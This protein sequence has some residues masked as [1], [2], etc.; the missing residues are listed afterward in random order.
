M[1][2][3]DFFWGA[4]TSS[5][6]IEGAGLRSDWH[7]WEGSHGTTASLSGN[8][9]R[10]RFV[11]DFALLAEHQL[12]QVRLTIEWARVEPFPGRLDRDELEHIEIVLSAAREAGISVW[13]T[14]HHGSLPGWFSEDTDGFC[15]TDGPSIHWS[16]HVDRMA[17]MFDEYISVWWPIDD[18]IG[19]AVASHHLGTRPPGVR[20]TDR[21]H[22]A[23][24]GV[25]D[26]TFDAHRLLA[27]GDSPVVA[28]FALPTI[29]AGSPDAE[30]DRRLWDSVFWASWSRGI[31][32][33]VLDLPWKA[34]AERSGWADA[35]DAIGVG[36]AAP[37]AAIQGGDL[38][39]WPR[40]GQ[41]DAALRRPRPHDLGESL[42]RASDAVA[43]KDLFVSGLGAA[44]HDDSW[45]ADLFEMWLDQ[46]G[47]A[48]R[49]GL[50]IRGAFLEPVIDGYDPFVGTHL[51]SGVFTRSREPKPSLGWISA[52]Q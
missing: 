30:D 49:E 50:P 21:L 18:P 12:S 47:V 39:A 5:V 13:A 15:S 20:S 25:L 7:R 45:R 31:A 19:W 52:Q 17:E 36:I 28:N 51:D 1:F 24:E 33:G 4:A 29:H 37:Y 32:D 10:T 42:Q 14:L 2:D 40:D 9:F 48:Q 44:T 6:A 23:V 8:D 27:S 26:A 34:T 43:G 38:V 35:F 16:R 46:I 11:E 41:S 3:D 22:D